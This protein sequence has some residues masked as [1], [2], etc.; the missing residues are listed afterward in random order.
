MIG[1]KGM[2]S[3]ALWVIE[4]DFVVSIAAVNEDGA[5]CKQALR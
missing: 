5:K 1:G 3:E 4:S 2:E